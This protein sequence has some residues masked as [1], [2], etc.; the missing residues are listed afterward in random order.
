MQDQFRQP[1]RLKQGSDSKSKRQNLSGHGESAKH[2]SS[3]ELSV[4]IRTSA[5][6]CVYERRPHPCDGEIRTRIVKKFVT[7]HAD[8]DGEIHMRIVKKFCD[9][10]CGLR[11]R[12]ESDHHGEGGQAQRKK[13]KMHTE[14]ALLRQWAWE[15]KLGKKERTYKEKSELPDKNSEENH[16]EL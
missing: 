8:L 10:A 7:A 13:Q 16:G 12:R 9:C 2:P 4:S 11:S 1:L 3:Q 14:Q 6:A 5:T 15:S